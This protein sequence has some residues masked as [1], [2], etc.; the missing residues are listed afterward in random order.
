[1]YT[2]AYYYYHK[3][4]ILEIFGV[5]SFQ[6]RKQAFEAYMKDLVSKHLKPK[7]I[8]YAM[9]DW[10]RIQRIEV[11]T[12]HIFVSTITRLFNSQEQELY[13]R[14]EHILTK[15]QMSLLDELV[16]QDPDFP[17]AFKLTELKNISQSEKPR[18]ID[19]SI[20]TFLEV[21]RYFSLLL[22]CM[23]A[24]KLSTDT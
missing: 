20:E 12:Y 13:T 11:P 1:M 22:P 17:H 6:E 23:N 10:L 21:K 14:L 4:T 16:Q 2:K 8:L 19:G 15:E 24:L 9:V 3:Q 18:Q 5:I 7:N